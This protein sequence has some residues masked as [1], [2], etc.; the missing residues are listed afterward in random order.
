MWTKKKLKLYILP[1]FCTKGYR[2]HPNEFVQKIILKIDI[3]G[4][5]LWRFYT[6]VHKRVDMG[7]YQ[8]CLD[9]FKTMLISG[10]HVL[11]HPKQPWTFPLTTSEKSPQMH[12]IWVKSVQFFF[13]N[14]W[15][16]P[17]FYVFFLLYVLTSMYKVI[18]YRNQNMAFLL[19]VCTYPYNSLQK[20]ENMGQ[21]L[22]IFFRLWVCF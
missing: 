8:K 9:Q 4:T 10:L 3:K 18:K 22:I 12:K 17:I 15:L 5:S 7:R 21:E 19:N 11:V 1:V 14:F 2:F 20:Q 13:S 16:F 6:L